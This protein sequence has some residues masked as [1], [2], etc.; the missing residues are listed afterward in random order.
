ME[1][2]IRGNKRLLISGG[3]F[4]FAS[5]LLI[6]RAFSLKFLF[7]KTF[8]VGLLILSILILWFYKLAQGESKIKPMKTYKHLYIGYMMTWLGST[9]FFATFDLPYSEQLRVL[10]PSIPILFIGI[11]VLFY[12]VYNRLSNKDE[13]EIKDSENRLSSIIGIIASSIV[14]IPMLALG[15]YAIFLGKIIGGVIFSAVPILFASIFY[16]ASRKKGR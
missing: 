5:I 12:F 14:L 2:E 3:M 6:F 1:I 15:L 9:F 13:N 16:F 8:S 10:I 7:F 11:I 4:L